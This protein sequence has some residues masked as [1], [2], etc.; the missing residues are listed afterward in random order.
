MTKTDIHSLRHQRQRAS[1]DADQSELKALAL[2]SAVVATGTYDDRVA[3]AMDDFLAEGPDAPDW[4]R[5]DLATDAAVGAT[6]DEIERRMKLLGDAYPFQLKS[7]NLEYVARKH[8]IYEFLLV[9]AVSPS[10]TAGDFVKLPRSFERVASKLVG[11]Y[12]GSDVEV[13]H[14]GWPRDNSLGFAKAMADVC[15]SCVEPKWQPQDGLPS[16]PPANGD[17][18]VDFVVRKLPPDGRAIGQMFLL[19]QCACGNDWDTKFNDLNMSSFG[20]WFNPFSLVPPVRAFAT[21]Y[22]L[23]DGWLA[24]ASREAGIIFDRIRLTALASRPEAAAL[25][26]AMEPI[27]GPLIELVLRHPVSDAA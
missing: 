12:V 3:S 21:P 20:K 18:G 27:V 19:G 23:V 11:L 16:A 25:V 26:I 14:T 17:G 10:L 7:G 8:P 1:K 22:C 5:E 15:A 6:Q 24:E 13:I 2:D 4:A 9:T